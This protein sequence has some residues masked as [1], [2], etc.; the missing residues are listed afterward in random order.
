MKKLALML[1]L[2]FASCTCNTSAGPCVGLATEDQ[3]KPGLTYKISWWNVALAVVFC[4]T[5]VVPAVVL[6]D[7]L[8]CPVKP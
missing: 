8:Q 7:N 3:K 5:L 6:I 2:M 4:E 1:C